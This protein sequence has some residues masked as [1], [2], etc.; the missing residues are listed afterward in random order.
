[1]GSPENFKLLEKL[2]LIL[3]GAAGASRAAVDA[4]WMSL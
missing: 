2:A 4:E 3:N 1:M